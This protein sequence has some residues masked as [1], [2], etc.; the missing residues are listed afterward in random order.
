MIGTIIG[1]LIVGSELGLALNK[2]EEAKKKKEKEEKEA[3]FKELDKRYVLREDEDEEEEISRS[4]EI[5][6]ERLKSRKHD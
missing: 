5:L 2:Q 1:G 3:L 4:E 6:R